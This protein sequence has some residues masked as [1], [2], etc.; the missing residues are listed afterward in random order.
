M[1]SKGDIIFAEDDPVLREVFKK[2]FTLEGYQ[3]R[4]TTDGDETIAELEKKLPHALIL[5]INMPGTNGFVVMERYPQ[6]KRN[7]PI[8]ILTNLADEHTKKK[9]EEL[10]AD[11]FFIKSEMTMKTLIDMV[12]DLLG[13]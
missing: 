3:V 11:G 7:F 6:E 5:D 13:K 2:K 10:G 1:K 4:T 9:G 8:V 12:N